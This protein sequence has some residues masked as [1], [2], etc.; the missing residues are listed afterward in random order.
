MFHGAWPAQSAHTNCFF[1][2]WEVG[3]GAFWG[4][5]ERLMAPGRSVLEPLGGSGEG[6]KTGISDIYI[7]IRV[8]GPERPYGASGDRIVVLVVLVV[9]VLGF[10]LRS[11]NYNKGAPAAATPL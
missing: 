5:G 2:F 8:R 11:T 10:L 6:Q 4:F 9:V 3:L 1:E 7:Y